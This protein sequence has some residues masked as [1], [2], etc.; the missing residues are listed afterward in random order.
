MC[1]GDF[2]MLLTN[3]QLKSIYFGALHFKETEDG[4]LQAFQYTDSQM[5]YFRSS[6]F[7]FWYE[8]CDA[9]NCKTF[10]M[11]TAATKISFAY[12]LIWKSSEDTVELYVDGLAYDIKY[13][14]DMGQEGVLSFD[15]PEGEKQVVFYLPSDATLLVKD[16]EINADFTPAQK[17]EKVLWIG[18]S[19]TQGYGPLRSS[20]TYV[21][22]ANRLLNYDILNQGI[23]G[24]VY[25]KNT[26]VPMEGYRPDKII[27]SM[28]TNQFGSET[29]D[30][31]E[32]Y[33]ECLKQVYGDT[34]VLCVSPLW[35]GDCPGQEAVLERFCDNVKKIA[36]QYPNVTVVDGFTLVPHLPEYFLDK[37]HPNC[38][39]ME[40]YGR[41]LVEFIR[42]VGF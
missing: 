22:V 21:S 34:P 39:G 31:V 37:L 14:K 10:E 41:N 19:I 27:I 25:D 28:G 33:Y 12:K 42:K 16:F 18:D 30:A 29:M 23:G 36:G 20:H 3:E 1:K 4:Y 32:E 35:R 2:Q 8:R 11:T 26:M 38:L 24:Y 6:P 15:L 13:V 7:T 9:S 17:G 40:L 5:D